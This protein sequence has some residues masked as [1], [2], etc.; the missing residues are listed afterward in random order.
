MFLGA[1]WGDQHKDVSAVSQTDLTER[2]VLS[3]VQ[4]KAVWE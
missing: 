4:A 3:A 2:L 1:L